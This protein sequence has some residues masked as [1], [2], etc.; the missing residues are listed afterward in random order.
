ME[1]VAIGLLAVLVM[2]AVAWP[3]FRGGRGH[4]AD[5]QEFSSEATSP[6]REPVLATPAESRSDPAASEGG[7]IEGEVAR[8]RQAITG[9][10]LCR[11]CGEANPP[12]SRFCRDCGKPLATNDAQEYA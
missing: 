12:G 11:R 10:T 2:G 9:G 1:I 7:G 6:P 3:L 5:A 4:A 8:Y